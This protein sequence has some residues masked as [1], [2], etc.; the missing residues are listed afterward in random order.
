MTVTVKQT[1]TSIVVTPGTASI[2]SGATQQF[3][4]QGLDQFQRAMATQ[5]HVHLERQRRHDQL[6]R[7]LHGPQHGRHL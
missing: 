3:N 6:R 7:A 4:A 2:Q 5:P 1:L